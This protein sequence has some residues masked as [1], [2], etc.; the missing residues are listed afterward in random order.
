M[1]DRV[2][3]MAA[4]S[5]PL[6][7]QSSLANVSQSSAKS[8]PDRKVSNAKNTSLHLVVDLSECASPLN[9]RPL[10]DIRAHL[11]LSLKGIEH[12]K[13]IEIKAMSRDNR[14]D[15]RYFL[16]VTTQVE[17]N[18]L[19]IHLDKWLVKVFPKARIQATTFYPIRV[20]S[21]NG[22]AILDSSTGQILPEAAL[23]IS[24]DNDNLSVGRIRWLSQPGKKYGSMVV[25]LKDKSEADAILTRG[26]LKVGGESATTQV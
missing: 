3:A 22:N 25:Y 16:F 7:G 8:G 21:V 10:K 17:E 26:F 14:Q 1:A 4:T 15:H 24:K 20:D 23:G 9:K 12:T 13:A 6:S 2:A 18:L 19:R 11:Q 5:A